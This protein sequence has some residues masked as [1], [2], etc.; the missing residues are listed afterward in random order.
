[1]AG[2]VHIDA[3][4]DTMGAYAAQILFEELALMTLKP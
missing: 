3:H 1:M 2:L 4:C